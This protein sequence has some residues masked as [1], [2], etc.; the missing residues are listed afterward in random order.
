MLRHYAYRAPFLEKWNARM[1]KSD[2]AEKGLFDDRA[3]HAMRDMR[4]EFEYSDSYRSIYS[5]EKLCEGLDA[6]SSAPREGRRK[7]TS[8]ARFADRMFA[9]HTPHKLKALRLDDPNLFKLADI[10]GD[11]SAGLTSYGK[12]KQEAWDE[13]LRLAILV[14]TEGKAPHPCLTGTRT[15]KNGKTRVIWSYPEEVMILE[16]LVARPLISQ[17]SRDA[18][19]VMAISKTSEQMGSIFN[20][21]TAE[22]PMVTGIDQSQFDAHVKAS[23]IHISFN[24]LKT[25]FDLEQE[26]YPGA[27]VKDVFDIVERYFIA[28]PIVFPSPK[29]PS[30]VLGKIGGVPSGS[31]FTQMVDSIVNYAIISDALHHLGVSFKKEHLFV[32]GDDSLIFTRQQ[33]NLR[34]ISQHLKEL[35]YKAHGPEKSGQWHYKQGF[36]FLGR[37]W[38]N[39]KPVRTV[40]DIADR[41]LYPE[42]WRKYD[43]DVWLIDAERLVRSYGL[44]AYIS[45]HSFDRGDIFVRPEGNSGYIQ[46]L[47]RMG[48]L[49]NSVQAMNLW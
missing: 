35:G 43:K 5:Y 47:G 12:T 18:R 37:R 46:F 11:K 20:Q 10:K 30:L 27:T 16:A 1:L 28:T 31:Y 13:A 19:G 42:K 8:G 33:V 41:A 45:D 7:L 15:Q 14:L 6:F 40:Q 38:V 49:P 24:I 25:W 39:F 3:E 22:S 44:T 29:G 36:E 26:V 32:L 21:I 23:H 17:F 48:L 4:M 34:A 2:D 9:N